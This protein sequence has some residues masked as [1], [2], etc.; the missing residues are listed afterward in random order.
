MESTSWVAKRLSELHA[1]GSDK[2]VAIV[3][4]KKEVKE[5]SANVSFLGNLVKSKEFR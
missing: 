1:E 2:T 3:V 5:G 4:T